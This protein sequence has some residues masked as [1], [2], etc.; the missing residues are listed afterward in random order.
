MLK[1]WMRILANHSWFKKNPNQNYSQIGH[2]TLQSSCSLWNTEVKPSLN[3]QCFLW[4]TSAALCFFSKRFK[5]SNRRARRGSPRIMNAIYSSALLCELGG[6]NAFIFGCG[7]R[8]R[9]VLSVTIHGS[10]F[11]LPPKTA[12]WSLWARWRGRTTRINLIFQPG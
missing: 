8:S 1:V 5:S 11:W 10:V 2:T 3:F 7:Q 6:F 12:V 4:Y 9:C